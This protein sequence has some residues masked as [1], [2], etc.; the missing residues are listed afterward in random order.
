M[1]FYYFRMRSFPMR[2]YIADVELIKGTMVWLGWDG[3]KICY[4]TGFQ[5]GI[6]GF[7]DSV[8]EALEDLAA[9]IRQK[10]ITVWVSMPATQYKVNG[11]LKADCPAAEAFTKCRGSIR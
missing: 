3:N 7:G 4:W 2:P 8:P 1:D 11:L 5:E 9:Q 10:N 6:G